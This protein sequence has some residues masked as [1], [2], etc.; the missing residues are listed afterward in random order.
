VGQHNS[1]GAIG[2]G[3]IKLKRQTGQSGGAKTLDL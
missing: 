2:E 1:A 3:L